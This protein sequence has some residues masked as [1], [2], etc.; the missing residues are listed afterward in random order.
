MQQSDTELG[1]FVQAYFYLLLLL[2]NIFFG[3]MVCRILA[4]QAGME[5][6]SPAL[7]GEVSITE[8]LGKL[9]SMI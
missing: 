1:P 3:C 9:L 7:E 8:P 5:L 6:A 2:L 4:P